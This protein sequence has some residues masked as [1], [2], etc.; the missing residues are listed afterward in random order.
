MRRRRGHLAEFEI[1]L[2]VALAVCGVSLL[3]AV[4]SPTRFAPPGGV[5]RSRRR[6]SGGSR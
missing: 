6:T 1:L 2:I 5:I 3:V 4:E